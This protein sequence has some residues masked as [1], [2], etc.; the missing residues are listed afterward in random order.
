M[1][2]MKRKDT[3]LERNVDIFLGYKMLQQFFATDSTTI[4]TT[5]L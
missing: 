3:K 4:F 2:R 1:A 5:I